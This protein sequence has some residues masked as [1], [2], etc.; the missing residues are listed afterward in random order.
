MVWTHVKL[1][2]IITAR[3]KLINEPYIIKLLYKSPLQ[4]LTK[5]YTTL[6][7]FSV[8]FHWAMMSKHISSIQSIFIIKSVRVLPLHQIFYTDTLEQK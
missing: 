1:S 6:T 7:N 5:I 3:K 4:T 8:L 2:I